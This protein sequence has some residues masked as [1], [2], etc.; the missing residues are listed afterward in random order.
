MA[1]KLGIFVSSD[2]NLRHLIEI[3]KAAEA[4]GREVIIFFTHKGVLLT[5][6]PEF[7]ELVGH[8]RKKLCHVSYEAKGLSGKPTPGLEAKD[9]GSQVQHGEMIDEVERYIVL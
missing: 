4:A 1:E 3:T 9:H 6:E 5:Q 7:Q 8:G 2:K